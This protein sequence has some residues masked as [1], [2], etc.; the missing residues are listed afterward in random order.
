MGACL[1][2]MKDSQT[3]EAPELARWLHRDCPLVGKL[4]LFIQRQ[5]W[6]LRLILPLSDQVNFIIAQLHPSKSSIMSGLLH[7]A[8]NAD[9]FPTA[10]TCYHE[11][12]RVPVLRRKHYLHRHRQPSLLLRRPH[13]LTTRCHSSPRPAPSKY[14]A[15][16]GSICSTLSCAQKGLLPRR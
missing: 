13:C 5:A 1:A 15:N 3:F 11:R 2:R 16:H 6:Y 14:R 8:L 4:Q 10:K 7:Q 9:P 12:L